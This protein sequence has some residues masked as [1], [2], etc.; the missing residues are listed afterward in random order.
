MTET[1]LYP[2]LVLAVRDMR[3]AN[4]RNETTGEGTGN[5]SWIGLSIAMT[6]L[7]TLT[8]GTEK[9]G[10]RWS[11]LLTSHDVTE[12][13]AK[14]IYALRCSL[15]HGYGPPKASAGT[16]NR[17]MLLTADPHAYAV[18]TSRAGVALV[19]VPVFCGRLVERIVFAAWEDW[20]Q[21]LVNTD[22][23]NAATPAAG[24]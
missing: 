19:S 4:G 24:G 9:V 1:S 16:A 2:T 5:E 10:Q 7:D 15:L 23:F 21:E 6:V 17:H 11:N 12:A 14:L 3:T 18:D 22:I 8:S 13:D 20:D